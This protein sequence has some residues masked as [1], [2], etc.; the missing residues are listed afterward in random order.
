MSKKNILLLL[1]NLLLLTYFFPFQSQAVDLE[2]A[3]IVL[4]LNDSGQTIKV[5]AK[6]LS[7]GKKMFNSTCSQCHNG[8]IT[9]TNPNVGL[10][11]EALS[12][13]TPPR[14]N[15]ANLVDYM[16]NP[17]SYDGIFPINEIHPSTASADIFAKMKNLSDKDLGAIAEYILYQAQ[18]NSNWGGGKIYY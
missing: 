14:N 15:I 7:R 11:I 4:P 3:N 1:T 10:D 16:Q 17:T 5:N 2:K 13:A 12:F 8:G 9:K 6:E 18:E